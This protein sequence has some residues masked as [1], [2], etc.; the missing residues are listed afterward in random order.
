MGEAKR[1]RQLDPNYGKLKAE[2]FAIKLGDFFD[3]SKSG[4]YVRGTVDN[5]ETS[6][7]AHAFREQGKI[8]VEVLFKMSSLSTSRWEELTS[9]KPEII[10]SVA[11]AYMVLYG[12]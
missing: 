7:T 6:F 11:T 1:R 8:H 3:V 9:A 5:A 2:K 12:G 4:A 10:K